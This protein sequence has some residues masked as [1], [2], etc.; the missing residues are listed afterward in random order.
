MKEPITLVVVDGQY[1]FCN[2]AG[3]LY[4]S[5][6]ETAVEH[7][8]HFIHTHE[9]L[10]EVIFTVDWHQA[11]DASFI[12]QGGPW[13]PHCIGFSKGSQIDER[14]VQAC[15]DREIPFR[16]IRKGEVIET[17]EYGAFQHIEKLS[18]GRY[19]LATM[20]DEVIC[21]DHRMVICG[22]A[23][24]YCVLETLRNLLNG[25]LSVDVFAS[26]IASI[27][28]GTKLNNFVREQNLTLC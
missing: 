26:G 15:L 14:L 23:G 11:R 19:R 17:E 20:T 6:A 10:A 7:I 1:D 16:V 3:A 24:D 21:A 8:L 2:P 28:G 18:G 25:G 13:P 9:R 12:P 5:G 27:D 4:V 22:V